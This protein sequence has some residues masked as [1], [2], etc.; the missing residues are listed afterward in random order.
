[1]FRRCRFALHSLP[2]VP[3]ALSTLDTLQQ[4]LEAAHL[5]TAPATTKTSFSIGGTNKADQLQWFSPQS[6]SPFFVSP[7][8]DG[9]RLISYVPPRTTTASPSDTVVKSRST[10]Q[11]NARRLAAMSSSEAG[12]AREPPM[13]CYSR[14]GRPIYGLFWIEE[15]LQLLRAL[16]GDPTL[17]VDG[18]LYLHQS[19]MDAA[20]DTS[21]SAHTV[22]T[23]DSARLSRAAETKPRTKKVPLS[24]LSSEGDPTINAARTTSSA[25]PFKTGFLAV[26]ALVHRLRGPSLQSATE[27]DI[28]QYVPALP[29]LCVFDIPSYSPSPNPLSELSMS[30]ASAWPSLLLSGSL[31]PRA[32]LKERRAVTAELQRVRRAAMEHLHIRD[33][34]QLRVVPNATPFSQRLRAMNFLFELLTIATASP[35]LQRHFCPSQTRREGNTTAAPAAATDAV[36]YHGGHHV[37]RIPYQLVTSLAETTQR[38]LPAYVRHNYEGAVIRSPLNTYNFKEKRKGTIAALLAPLLR[39]A[40]REHKNGRARANRSKRG[41][42]AL[43]LSLAGESGASSGGTLMVRAY[44]HGVPSVEPLSPIAP[45]AA[46]LSDAEREALDVVE[47][48]QRAVQRDKLLPRRSETAVK[49]LAYHDREY[50]ILRPLLKEPSKNPNTRVLVSI[51]RSSVSALGYPIKPDTDTEGGEGEVGGSRGKAPK[52]PTAKKKLSKVAGPSPPA[53]ASS[54]GSPVVVFYGLQCLAENGLV[55]N[56]S[57]PKLTLTQQRAL[58][59]HLL[60]AGKRSAAAGR[61]AKDTNAAAQKSRAK[62][63]SKGRQMASLTGL[64]A[65]VKFSTLTEH[66]LPRFGTVKAIRGGKGWFM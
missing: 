58:L 61:G 28:L 46:A 7:K 33:V 10:K 6:P 63:T 23:H 44:S 42:A 30:S 51:P 18:E 19:L 17:I 48:G 56:V 60:A 11:K 12:K 37:C 62:K 31:N 27:K 64:Y 65:T 9:V 24:A 20:S 22:G 38:L 49:V 8:H 29:H 43:L 40:P 59:D 41:R 50:A 13:T 47:A 34:E 16:C 21:C 54:E 1:M 66:G 32:S 39:A 36:T 26:S 35:V 53:A 14:Y 15:E 3:M 57:M 4:R 55:F 5:G 45:S 25:E 52:A 2:F